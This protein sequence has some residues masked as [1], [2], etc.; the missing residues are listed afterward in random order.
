MSNIAN[1]INFYTAYKQSVKKKPAIGQT[2]LVLLP[3]AA[4]AIVLAVT[5][6]VIKLGN[7]K[8][9]DELARTNGEIAAVQQA[10]QQ[11]LL[12]W[13]QRDT[14]KTMETTLTGMQ[15]ALDA[16]PEPDEELLNDVIR[17]AGDR[18]LIRVYRYDE[19]TRTLEI[20]AAGGSV[21]DV[22]QLVEDL[23]DTGRF[24]A[25]QYKGYT[26]DTD[27]VYYCTVGCTLAR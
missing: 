12:L 3:L 16:L 8:K 17:C 26:S 13:Q 24:S 23:R 18:F 2:W 20:D 6:V 10:Q 25:V 5:A 1:N 19:E 27:G 11:S 22:P 4:L 14:L 15:Q 9:A 7:A 21:N